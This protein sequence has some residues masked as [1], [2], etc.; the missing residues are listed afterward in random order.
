MCGAIALNEPTLPCGC[1]GESAV[2]AVGKEPAGAGVDG[3]G[4]GVDV[5]VPVAGVGL[6]R[7]QDSFRLTLIIL[8][9]SP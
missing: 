3:G 1:A 7:S 8:I 9:K 5:E 2:D 6:D 4:D